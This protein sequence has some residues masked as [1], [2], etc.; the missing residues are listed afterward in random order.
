MKLKCPKCGSTKICFYED[1]T[2]ALRHEIRRN[3]DG[4]L[5]VDDHIDSHADVGDLIPI[6][7][8]QRMECEC[9]EEF[10]VPA[11]LGRG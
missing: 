2:V 8:S 9:G 1:V 4:E 11:E 7:G 10:P 6:A 3:N 5:E